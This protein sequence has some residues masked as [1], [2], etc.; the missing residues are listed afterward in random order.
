MALVRRAQPWL[1][2]LVEISLDAADEQAFQS[3]FGLIGEIHSRMSYH[4]N[5]SD[6]ALL[7]SAA[8]GTTVTV[9]PHTVE[10]LR[11][12]KWLFDETAGLFD[13]GIGRR[14]VAAGYLPKMDGRPLFQF[15]GNAGDIEIVD[16]AHVVCHR[17]ILI[18]L[19]GIAKGY[20]VD[21]AL[22]GLADRGCTYAL[23]NAG[24]DLR[25]MG[26]WPETIGLRGPDG[27][28]SHEIEIANVAVATS[29]NFLFRR[30]S[31][32]RVVSPHIGRDLDPLLI[33]TAVT[34]VA[35]ECTLADAMTKIAMADRGLAE[36]MLSK[37]GGSFFSIPM[38]EDAA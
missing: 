31:R 37:V 19:G 24:G 34:V 15:T 38:K 3:A 30:K 25:H 27:V 11:L 12:A 23:I 26:P 28:V 13:I 9:S 8:P 7:R 2:T 16:D 1:G 21:V 35:P 5:D 36:H 32:G 22:S 33:D 4:S 10:V 6:L 20:A 14:L 29:S 17:P 18:D